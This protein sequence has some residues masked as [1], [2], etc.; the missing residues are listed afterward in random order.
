MV[1]LD[2]RGKGC[3]EMFIDDGRS[4]TGAEDGLLLKFTAEEVTHSTRVH[5]LRTL[6]VPLYDL[7]TM[8]VYTC[9]EC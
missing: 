8:H 2:G 5:L 3:G 9:R 1:A 7:Y 4:L 6:I